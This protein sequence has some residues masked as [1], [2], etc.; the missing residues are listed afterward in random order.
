MLW[1]SILGYPLFANCMFVRIKTQENFTRTLH[2]RQ[3]I[4]FLRIFTDKTNK[5]THPMQAAEMDHLTSELARVAG[6]ER[7]LIE[8]CGDMLFKTCASQ[9]CLLLSIAIL[10]FS[11][12]LSEG[13]VEIREYLKI[14]FCEFSKNMLFGITMT[15]FQNIL[16]VPGWKY[17][18][19]NQVI[20]GKKKTPILFAF[21]CSF[22][23]QNEI[24]VHTFVIFINS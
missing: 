23:K 10:L 8:D 1:S 5:R 22:L 14:Q 13:S 17:F 4:V 16:N 24:L 21:F 20:L 7:A 2:L 18:P 15:C 19:K 11:A 9:V 6:G 12:E 3:H